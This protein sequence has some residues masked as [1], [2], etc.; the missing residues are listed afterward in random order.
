MGSGEDSLQLRRD[1]R[2]AGLSHSTVPPAPPVC[3]RLAAQAAT[4]GQATARARAAAQTGLRGFRS[5]AGAQR[6]HP[7]MPSA[8]TWGCRAAASSST[9][10][11]T[12]RLRSTRHATHSP[13]PCPG[14]GGRGR[15]MIRR[16]RR[17]RLAAAS[18]S[19]VFAPDVLLG[20]SSRCR[21]RM[22]ARPRGTAAHLVR[23]HDGLV[24]R[25]QRVARLRRGVVIRAGR[26]QHAVP[27]LQQ[28]AARGAA[29]NAGNV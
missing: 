9:P 29:G 13:V 26:D 18:M 8:T 24:G 15:V 2:G 21:R 14:R 27:R 16:S 25:K 22:C 11:L 19:E 17:C 5:P 6:P 3:K 12:L 1:R 28:P 10:S 20:A 7:P 23:R 4:S